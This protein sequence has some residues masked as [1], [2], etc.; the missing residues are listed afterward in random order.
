MKT[1]RRLLKLLFAFGAIVLIIAVFIAIFGALAPSSRDSGGLLVTNTPFPTPASLEDYLLNFYLQQHAADIDTPASS[2]ATPVVFSILPGELPVDVAT[3]LQSQGLV[4][5]PDLFLKL[6]KYL[7]VDT[8]I[9]AGEYVLKRTMKP[10]EILDAFQHGRAKTVTVTVRPG[11]RAEEIADY[12]ATLGLQNYDKDEFLRLVKAGNFDYAFLKDRPKNATPSVE[13]FLFPETYNVP[14]DVPT[15]TLITLMLDTFNSRVNEGTRQKAAA[16]KMTLYEVVALASIVEREAVVADERAVIASVFLNRIK[17]KM[18]L[19][20]DSTAQ[21]AI[22]YQAA[23]KQWW[24]SPVTIEELSNANSPYNTYRN[25]GLPPGPICNPS[26][27]SI[28][29]AADPA[30]SDYLFYFS[31][32]DGTHAFGKTFEEHQ[33]NQQKYGK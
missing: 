33:Q 5:D 16:Q 15:A 17:K 31:K 23:T 30:Q 25:P 21:Y 7:R 10:P 3:R 32:G 12:L 2:D 28:V 6:A 13:G 24:K 18:F 11:W 1:W 22:G 27:A 8:N 20:A 29:A 14:Y 26:L 9:Q 4:K 19:Q